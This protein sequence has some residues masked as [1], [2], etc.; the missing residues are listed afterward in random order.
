MKPS[1]K[2][3]KEYLIGGPSGGNDSE[4]WWHCEELLK[5]FEDSVPL[6]KHKYKPGLADEIPCHPDGCKACEI[7]DRF[8]E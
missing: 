5:A 2:Y 3:I 1:L 4:V 7:I 6:L 8:G